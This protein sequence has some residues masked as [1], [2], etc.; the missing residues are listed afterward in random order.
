MR[1][2]TGKMFPAEYNDAIFVS[3]RGSWNRSTKVGYDVVVVRA[4]ADGKGAKL[5]PF[6]TGFLDQKTN[7][8]WG[9]P[10]DVLQMPDGSDCRSQ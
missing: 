9:R 1:F 10:V 5:T 8:F 3:R 4:T 2:Y 7:Q 6:L